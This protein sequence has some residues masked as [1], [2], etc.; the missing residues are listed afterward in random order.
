[1]GNVATCGECHGKG[2]WPCYCGPCDACGGKGQIS[3]TCQSCAGRGRRGLFG[4]ACKAC[5]GAGRLQIRCNQCRGGGQD[6]QCKLCNGTGK[7][8]CDVCAGCGSRKLIELLPGLPIVPNSFMD[9]VEDQMRRIAMRVSTAREVDAF[10]TQRIPDDPWPSGKLRLWRGG[11]RLEFA[12][13]STTHD[14][15]VDRVGEDQYVMHSH[16]GGA[17]RGY[18]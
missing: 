12:S 16:A 3:S 15:N 18:P 4:M 5:R 2:K 6:P 9:G 7:K 13:N 11:V 17:A 1:M 10:L 14:I 8:Q